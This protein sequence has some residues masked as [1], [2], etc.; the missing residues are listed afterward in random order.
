[1]VVH[2]VVYSEIQMTSIDRGKRLLW[3]RINCLTCGESSIAEYI[4]R[5]QTCLSN[6]EKH[7]VK[8]APTIEAITRGIGASL[9][10]SGASGP[11]R[12]P[13]RSR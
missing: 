5:L 6:P 7:R 4:S 8:D 1:M 9:Q 10:R 3:W 12:S 2:L 13:F 11:A